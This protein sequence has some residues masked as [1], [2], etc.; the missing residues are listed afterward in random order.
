[1]FSVG[2]MKPFEDVRAEG[3]N[4][5][6]PEADVVSTSSAF[7]AVGRIKMLWRSHRVF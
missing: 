4:R 1:V 2:S 5:L 7:L 3:T 6:M